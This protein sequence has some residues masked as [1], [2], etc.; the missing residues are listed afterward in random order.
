M[1]RQNQLVSQA[2]Q[3]I[4]FIVSAYKTIYSGRGVDTTA[5][6]VTDVTCNGVLN[7]FFPTD[8][9]NSATC[10][11]GTNSTYPYHP[12]AGP[13]RVR[14]DQPNQGIEVDYLILPQTAC[15]KLASNFVN[16]GDLMIEQVNSD[17]TGLLAPLGA[18]AQMTVT[19]ITGDC[20]TGNTNNV[21]LTF[22]AR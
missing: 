20:G 12:W 15:I 17:S 18:N 3:Q 22:R 19:R 4:A 13:V 7:S 6:A 21:F 2:Q 9:A 10:T 1:V 14:A 5:G 16:T 8:M 11:T